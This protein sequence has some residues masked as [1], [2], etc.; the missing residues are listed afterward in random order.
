MENSTFSFLTMPSEG[1]QCSVKKLVILR[2]AWS[3]T[4]PVREDSKHMFC[5]QILLDKYVQKLGAS[6]GLI[7]IRAQ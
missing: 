4:V 1:K 5:L 7:L 2:P 6:N 3:P